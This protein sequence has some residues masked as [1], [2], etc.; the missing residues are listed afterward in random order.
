MIDIKKIYTTKDG[1][2]K[3]IKY[4]SYNEVQI[5]FLST[6]GIN[7]VTAGNIIKG[8][9]K[10][11]FKRNVQSVA[12]IGGTVY[13]KKK[14]KIAYEAWNSMLKRCYNLNHLNKSPTYIN[15]I[16]DDTWLN[17]QNFAPW[18][19]Q[20]Y[21]STYVLDKDIKNINNKIYSAKNCLLVPKWLNALF[22]H[23]TYV[24][25][26]TYN[27]K[28]KAV[29][30]Y[31]QKTVCGQVRNTKQQAIKEAIDLYEIKLNQILNDKELPLSLVSIIQQRINTL[32][33]DK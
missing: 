26:E 32:T 33:K 14:N 2:F 3:I 25:Q 21:K 10:D 27:N 5:E 22:K 23:K 29:Y 6:G 12:Y 8:H 15:C 9:V 19:E 28:F 11:L 1:E 31:R 17:F 4:L 24:V 7:T 16:V 30:N 20:H 18:F 13:S